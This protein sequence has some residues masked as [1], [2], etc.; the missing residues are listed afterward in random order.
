[1]SPRHLPSFRSSPMPSASRFGV[2]LAAT[3]SILVIPAVVAAPVPV[4]NLAS[5]VM[6]AFNGYELGETILEAAKSLFLALA[7]ISVVWTMGALIIRQDIGEMLMELLRFIVVTG[8]FYWL[9]INASSR[10]G[11]EDFVR[12]IV[13][14]FFQMSNGSAEETAIRSHAD[15]LLSRGLN[16][17][18][19]VI[20][21]TQSGN[22]QD[23]LLTGGIAVLILVMCALMA[24]QFVVALVM[25][26]VV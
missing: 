19:R 9:L 18:Y 24:A 17:F 5:D 1:M 20:A 26:W 11:G 6:T 23:Q 25:A 12:D 8:T 21:E 2:A 10:E 16:V 15:G 4:R 13:G 22:P 14:S 7:T 3:L